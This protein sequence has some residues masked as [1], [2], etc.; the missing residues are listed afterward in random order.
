MEQKV[1]NIK[2][3]IIL[4]IRKKKMA[5][6]IEHDDIQINHSHKGE[7]GVVLQH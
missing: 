5:V 3:K 6:I 1:L 2:L 7:K 4:I